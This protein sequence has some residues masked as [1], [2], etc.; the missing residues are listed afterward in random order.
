MIEAQITSRKKM[1]T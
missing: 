1:A